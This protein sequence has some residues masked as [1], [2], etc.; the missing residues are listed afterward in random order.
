M[1]DRRR[2]RV[3]AVPGAWLFTVTHLVLIAIP[4]AFGTVL[5]AN[6]GL[7]ET[8]QNFRVMSQVA[9]QPVWAICLLLASACAVGG[10]MSHRPGTR[11]AGLF[12]L[13]GAHWM[14]A[15]CNVLA[16]PFNTA[17]TTYSLLAVLA[18]CYAAQARHDC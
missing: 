6:P 8:A 9:S 3:P 4:L 2:R 1:H 16:L 17:S 12:V 14:I 5:L 18:W 10:I 15:I 13:G 7:F 11:C